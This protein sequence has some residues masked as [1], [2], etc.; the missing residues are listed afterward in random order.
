LALDLDLSAVPDS[1]RRVFQ[2]LV[3]IA[4][5]EVD[6]D[7]LLDELLA[8]GSVEVIDGSTVRCLSRAYVPR[9]ADVALIERMGRFL[10]AATANFVHNLLRTETEPLYLERTVVSDESLSNRGRD[11]FLAVA[12]DR[13][14][15]LL[16]E[17]DTFLAGIAASEKLESGKRYGVGVYFFEDE[18][19]KSEMDRERPNQIKV[20]REKAPLEEIDVLAAGARK[21]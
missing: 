8:A 1:P 19:A 2:E 15:E 14:Q 13:G 9:G 16:I 5:P 17:L 12:K 20:V 4:C 7:A 6:R 3:N 10:G 18:S 11:Q 21:E